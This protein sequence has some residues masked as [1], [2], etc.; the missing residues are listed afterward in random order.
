M[1]LEQGRRADA[2][3]EVKNVTLLDG[4]CL[5]FPDAVSV[6]GRK[7]LD[8]LLAAVREGQRGVIL[9]ALNRP[10]GGHFA[11][12]WNIDPAYGQR[13]R[14]VIAAGVEALAVRI[15]HGSDGLSAHGTV[16]IIMDR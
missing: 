4:D 15:C 16:P 13:L 3:V 10:E 7:H 8:L 11:P 2:W 1:R 12:A 9:F 6:R 5:R 14:E